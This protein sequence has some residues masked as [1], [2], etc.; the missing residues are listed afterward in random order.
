MLLNTDLHGQNVGRKMTCSEFI[1]N[2]AGLNECENFPRE[3]LKHLYQAIKNYPLEW[4]LYV[5]FYIQVKCFIEHCLI[6]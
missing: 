1:D 5:L 2:L 3:I 4:A 6:S